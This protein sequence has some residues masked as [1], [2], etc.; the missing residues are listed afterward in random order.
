[1]NPLHPMSHARN[2]FV[3]SVDG[4]YDGTFW[5]AIVVLLVFT[6][7]ALGAS[8]VIYDARRNALFIDDPNENELDRAKYEREVREGEEPL[9]SVFSR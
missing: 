1:M 2:L 4:I 8:I 6:A 3:R 5:I 7:L 9:Q